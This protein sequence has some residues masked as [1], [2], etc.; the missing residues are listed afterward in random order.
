MKDI[1][2][3]KERMMSKLVELRS[4]LLDNIPCITLI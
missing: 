1:D 3:T 2:K 4:T